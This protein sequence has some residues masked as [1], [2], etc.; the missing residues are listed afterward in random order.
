MPKIWPHIRKFLVSLKLTVALLVLSMLLVFFATL[1]Q[2]YL[3]IWAVQQK[4]FHSFLVYGAFPNGIS[5]PLFPGGYLIGGLLFLNLVAGHIYRFRLTA[6]KIGLLL[7]HLGLLMLLLGIFFAGI[8]QEDF[9]MSLNQGQTA[10]YAESFFHN[11]LAIIDT[12]APDRD[13]VTAIPEKLLER[14]TS[15]NAAASFQHRS[16]PFRVTVRAY[17]P[18][19]APQMR[20]QTAPGAAP[21]SALAPVLATAGLGTQVVL[22]PLPVTNRTDEQNIPSAYI[23]LTGA[24]G[25]SLGT[26]LVTTAID[27]PQTF[28][29]QNKTWSLVLRS[30]RRY[31][32]FSLQLLAV[33]NDVY[34]GSDIPKNF[35]SR[36]LL[37]DANDP[38]GREVTIYMNNPLRHDGLTFY[39]YQ[40][41][42]A[43]GN[44]VFQV[45]RNPARVLPYIACLLTG[46]GLLLH[47][48]VSLAGYVKTRA[49]KLKNQPSV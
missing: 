33:T 47:F 6:K 32:D 30:A 9:R 10:S 26:W 8:W 35:S 20:D 28:T 34:P 41:S 25:A 12:T 24:D 46:I 13:N 36:V 19:S 15:S 40:M 7:A 31:F 38:A 44:S 29:Y 4:W 23:E 45:V 48:L 2:K 37:R 22:A 27:A 49:G 43:T 39:Q 3:G 5:I 17:Y 14:A 18:N 16:L 21:S 11:E 42:A 1:D